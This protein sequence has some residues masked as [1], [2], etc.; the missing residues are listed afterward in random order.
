LKGRETTQIQIS[1]SGI[2]SSEQEAYENAQTNM[3][4]L[5]TILKTGSLPYKLRIE[6]IDKISPTLGSEFTQT[7]ILAGL[8]AAAGV[9]IIVFI[10]YRRLKIS[11]LVVLTMGSEI[12]IVLGLGALIKWNLDLAG[13]AGIIASIG[14]GV[15]DQIV[16]LDESSRSKEISMKQRIKIALAI[17]F[18]AYATTTVSLLPLMSAG[19][20]LLAGFA[21]TTLI[22]IT[23]GVFITR[24][25]FADI[26]EQIRSD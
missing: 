10:K 18:T 14:T 1:G 12:L 7:I 11:T 9:F 13:I 2:G 4:K 17:I 19:A 6:K 20:G 8:I 5:Q 23:A 16:V 25:A 26:V 22:G 15:D 24:P 3:K 21:I